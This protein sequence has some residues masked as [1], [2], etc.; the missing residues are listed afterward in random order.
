MILIVDDESSVRK[1]VARVI[2]KRGFEPI[3]ARNGL[4]AVEIFGSYHSEIAL[5]ISDVQ[6]P[7]MDGLEAID[8]MREMRPG[9]R[10]IIMTGAAGEFDSRG[11]PLL[12]KPFTPAR[13]LE[14]VDETLTAGGASGQRDSELSRGAGQVFPGSG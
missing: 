7:V 12:R 4:E 1:V 8:R 10:A 2:E 9:M 11:C 5:V 13:L 3:H 6:M 14:C